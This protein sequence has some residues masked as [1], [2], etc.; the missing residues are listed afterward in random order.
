M[1]PIVPA[2]VE[3][4]GIGIRDMEGFTVHFGFFHTP[5]SRQCHSNGMFRRSVCTRFGAPSARQPVKTQPGNVSFQNDPM[6]LQI[7]RLC[8]SGGSANGSGGQWIWWSMERACQWS[9]HVDRAV[10]LRMQEASQPVAGRWSGSDTTGKLPPNSCIPEGCQQGR[11]PDQG[12][13][14][15]LLGN[16]SSEGRAACTPAGVP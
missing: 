2:F 15:F 11:L 1:F 14:A 8:K 5:F 10:C 4:D 13:T 3:N 6:S 16:D 7:G 12:C 9:G